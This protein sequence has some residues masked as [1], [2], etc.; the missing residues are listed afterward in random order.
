MYVSSSILQTID[1]LKATLGPIV[2][3]IVD[4]RDAQLVREIMA[5]VEERTSLLDQIQVRLAIKIEYSQSIYHFF[6][7]SAM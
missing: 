6:T 2:E 5:R 1:D 4:Q 3:E 7:E